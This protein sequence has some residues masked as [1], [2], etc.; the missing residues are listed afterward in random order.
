MTLGK[1]LDLCQ[2][3]DGTNNT[4]QDPCREV[5]VSVVEGVYS[6][7]SSA[8]EPAGTR[9]ALIGLFKI[10]TTK[11]TQNSNVYLAKELETKCDSV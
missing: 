1:S 4:F 11:P 5:V 7:Y 6:I 3:P 8:G 10:Q 2:H 9:Q